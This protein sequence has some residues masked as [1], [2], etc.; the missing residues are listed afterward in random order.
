MLRKAL[1]LIAI[2][3]ALVQYAM[4]DAQS[5]PTKSVRIIVPQ[6]PGGASDA[7]ARIIGQKLSEKWD[8]P[9][10]IDNR[11][12]AGENIGMDL[13]A[14]SP[15]DGYTLLLSCSRTF[16]PSPN[17][18]IPGST[19]I[20]VWSFCAGRDTVRNREAD[21]RRRERVAQD[22]GGDGEIFS[23]G[24]GG[25]PILSGTVRGIGQ[26]RHHQVVEGGQGL[27]RDG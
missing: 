16:Q 25:L 26:D 3:A 19:S 20:H 2:G 1:S 7:L 17:P 27:G 24:S 9:V 14:K 15:A 4:A 21:Q 6:T 5:F 12:G 11:P 8:Q 22:P 10:V 23:A 13:V 18:A